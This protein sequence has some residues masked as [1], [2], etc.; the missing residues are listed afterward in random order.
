MAFPEDPLGLR[1]ALRL[2]TA[3]TDITGKCLTADPITHTRG[4]VGGSVAGPSSVPLKINNAGGLFSPRNPMS[5]YY[6]LIGRNTPVRLWLP[7]GT[8]FLD[9]DGDPAT[10]ATTPDAATLDITGDIDLRAEVEMS[11][12]QAGAQTLIG[13]WGAAGQRSYLL[14]V[15]NGSLYFTYST[16]GTATVFVARVLPALPRRAALRVTVDVDNGSGGYE[17]RHY[18][19]PTMAG[20][21]TQFADPYVGAGTVSLFSG[22]APLSIAPSDL[23]QSPPR[24]PFAGKGYKFE[25]RNG[26]NGSVVAS[27][28]FTAQPVGAVSFADSAG[29]TWSYTGTAAVADRQELFVGEVSSWPQKWVPSGELVW[30][31]VTATGLLRRLEQGEKPLDSTLRRRIPSG[32]PYAYWPFEEDRDASR[33][34]SPIAGV[35]P[36]SV[37]GVEFAAV[38]TLPSSKA[39]PKL[40]AAATLSAIVPTNPGGTWQVEVVYNADDKAPASNTEILSVSTSG[41]VRRWSLNLRADAGWVYG[42]NS[43]GTAIVDQG[44]G[45]GADVFHGWVRMRFWVRESGGTVTW[46]YFFQDIGGDAGGI[47]RTFAGTSGAVTALTANWQAATEGWAVGHLSVLPA[48]ESSLYTG[49]D[50]AY[51]GETAWERL[52]RL[53]T[54]LSLP[55]SRIAGEL[56]PERV[57]PQRP[58]TLTALFQA[59][60]DADGGMLLEEQTRLGLVYRDRSSLYSQDPALTLTYG[61]PGLAPPLDPVD[62]DT[63]TRNDRTIKRDGG[64]EGRAVLA[65]GPLSV[66]APPLGVGLYDDSQTLSLADDTQTEPIASWQLHLGTHDGARYPSVKVLLHNAPSLIPQVLALREGDLI[67]I[68]GLPPWVAFGDVDLLV[69]GWTETLRPRAW[70]RTFTCEP[71]E[72]WRTAITNVIHEDFED[73]DY[74]V[75]LTNGGNLPWTRTTTRYNSGTYSLRSGAIANNQTSDAVVALP[76]GATSLAFWYRVSSEPSG[77]GFEGDRLLVLVD[78][79]QVLRAQGEVGWTKVTLDVTGKSSVTYRYVKDNSSASG[80]D[81]AFIDDLRITVGAQPSAKVGSDGGSTLAIPLGT[82]DTL[83]PVVNSGLPWTSDPKDMPIPLVIAGEEVVCTSIAT[84]SDAFGRTVA[85]GW[86]TA[87]SGQAWTAVGGTAGTDYAVSSGTGRHVHTSVNVARHT[88]VPALTADVDLRVDWSMSAQPLTD[89]AYV[90]LMARYTD[91]THLYFARVQVAPGGAMT[92]SVRKLNGAEVQLGTFATGL[93]HVAG[94]LYRLR[95]EVVGTTLRA[96]VWLAASAEPGAWQISVTDTD[97]TAIG[98]VGVR[99]LLGPATTTP[100]P[101]AVQADNFVRG[102]PQAMTV[103]RSANGVVKSHL[104]GEPVTLAHPAI[105]PL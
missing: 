46:G 38:D 103:T 72:P 75:A 78:G 41:T 4:L 86:G 80:E 82:T 96:K 100:L 62:D 97:L 36:A 18:W 42:Y 27:P 71:G 34:Y 51:S 52:R 105:T 13:K 54:E 77:P 79:V 90:S 15:Q 23:A 49:S 5:P 73:T 31:S 83:M 55:I 60:A 88:V 64:S 92:L 35:L 19:A 39:L 70:E 61:A 8:K 65:T 98:S 12:Y 21:W 53:S 1:V 37:T 99:S 50:R 17:V 91:T 81:A 28:D 87:E 95:F 43:S 7:G 59:A 74:A 24:Y 66:Q 102:G 93:T 22:T 20:P 68:K 69:T 76:S 9:L 44:V 57:G 89:S 67:R 48:A 3:W 58:E 11:W 2:G 94:T 25:V 45:L 84:V 29:R 10:T 104:A 101:V 16:D 30:T 40:S 6:G 47:S 63:A 85:G 32:N 14:R 33:A 26:I 56:T